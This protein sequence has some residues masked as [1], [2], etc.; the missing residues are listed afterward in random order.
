[1]PDVL[2][3]TEAGRESG[4]GHLTRCHSLLDAFHQSGW[5]GR[6]LVQPDHLEDKCAGGVICTSWRESPGELGVSLRTASLVIIDSY[7]ISRACQAE[8]S[9][10]AKLCAFIDDYPHREY[11]GGC[12]ID[13]T[14]GAETSAYNTRFPDV[15]Y[16]LG[17]TYACLRPA[18]W[19]NHVHRPD[20]I[21]NLLLT[22]G[23][24]DI[25]QLTMPAL[26][27][28]RSVFPD[29]F[30]H[31]VLGPDAQQTDLSSCCTDGNAKAY[32][33][34]D[35]HTM[36]SLMSSCDL[37]LCGG[38]QTLYELAACGLPAVA[39][40]LAENQ[41]DDLRGFSS[42]EV[43]DWIGS[44]N[45]PGIIERAISAI[46]ALKE[47]PGELTRRAARGQQL[48]DGQGAMRLVAQLVRAS[49]KSAT[50]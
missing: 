5:Q 22:F 39:V 42:A 48:I 14:I 47:R 4:H 49:T 35:E 38:G 18:F 50:Y 12:V 6:V 20:T 7:L 17:S 24:S 2:I 29:I 45:T 37:A 13:W 28:I 33:S 15:C 21:R 32:R 36:K 11:V 9:A 8:I 25:R 30:V 1:M 26:Q 40:E 46:G 19:E 43:I 27:A 34:A 16:L 3:L 44:W 10:K 41:R 31:V 23:G